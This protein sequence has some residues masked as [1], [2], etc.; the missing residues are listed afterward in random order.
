M[1]MRSRRKGKVG[2]RE[3]ARFLTVEGFPSRRGVQYKGGSESP[4]VMCEALSAI[5][6][7][8]KRCERL[9]LYDALDQAVRECGDSIPIVAHRRNNCRW[10]AILDLSD[11]LSILRESSLCEPTT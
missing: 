2:E 6:F 7:E 1:S 4:D 3:L 5:H 11:L 9:S 10:V 8:S